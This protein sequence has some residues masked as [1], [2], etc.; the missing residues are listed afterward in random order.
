MKKGKCVYLVGVLIL[1]AS[2]LVYGCSPP[3]A[4][5]VTPPPAPPPVVHKF[6]L[7]SFLGTGFAE[8]EVLLP[9]FVERVK[10]MSGGRLEITLYPPGAL[11]PV[12]ETLLG[13]GKGVVEM[14]Y[15]ATVYWRGIMPVAELAWGVPMT[16]EKYPE[17]Y[18]YLWWELGLLDL[19][20]KVYAKHNVYFLVPIWSDEWGATMSTKPITSLKDFKGLKIRS[21]GIVGDIWIKHGASIVWLPGGEIYT[22]LATGTIDA[23]NWG[24]PYVFYVSKHHEVAKYYLEPSLIA[25]DI[26]DLFVNLDVWKALPKDLQEILTI[27]GRIFAIERASFSNYASCL[28]VIEM[29]KAGV[30]FTRLPDADLKLIRELALEILD[31]KAKIDPD[32]AAA[33][34]IIK[35]ALKVFAVRY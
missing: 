28:A 12:M 26:E 5:P 35:D 4:P 15:A 31:E 19:M 34:K 18:E 16:F 17:D 2:V 25:G 30:T 9:R 14:G 6:K 27:A 8:W 23:A 29:K 13:V 10:T 33:V 1:I 22:A 3:P 21:F 32:C 20:R 7:Q 11:V 24:S